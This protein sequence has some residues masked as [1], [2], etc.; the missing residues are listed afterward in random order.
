MKE[1]AF[2]LG[3]SPLELLGYWAVWAPTALRIAVGLGGLGLLGLA[4]R[5]ELPRWGR[6]AA[7][8]GAGV[9]FAAMAVQLTIILF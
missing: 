4:F 9:I 3:A 5:E 2:W 1:G 7:G 8:I 6:I